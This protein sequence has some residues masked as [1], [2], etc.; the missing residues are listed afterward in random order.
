MFD[1]YGED[2]DEVLKVNRN[3]V[4]RRAV[5]DFSGSMEGASTLLER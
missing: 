3:K 4:G 5:E 2:R 1:E